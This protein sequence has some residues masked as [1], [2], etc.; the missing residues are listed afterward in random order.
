MCVCVSWSAAVQASLSNGPAFNAVLQ[1][2]LKS[3]AFPCPVSGFVA[4]GEADLGLV[5]CMHAWVQRRRLGF[6]PLHA[7]VSAADGDMLVLPWPLDVLVTV[8]VCVCRGP[9][10]GTPGTEATASLIHKCCCVR[11]FWILGK[12]S[13]NELYTPMHFQGRVRRIRGSPRLL[14]ACLP[15]HGR[16]C[17][18]PPPPSHPLTGPDGIRPGRSRLGLVCLSYPRVLN[19]T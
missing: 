8:C 6:G 3:A 11:R 2:H 18:H 14:F 15:C 16:S 1:Q 17:V 19:V 4:K 7:C 5:H 10:V 13:R 9:C 12:G